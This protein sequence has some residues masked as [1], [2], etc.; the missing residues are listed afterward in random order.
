MSVGATL[1]LLRK[2]TII[3]Y[4]D[5]GTMTIAIDVAGSAYKSVTYV[6]PL[7]LAWSNSKGGIV[8]GFPARGSA[9]IATQGQGGSWYVVSYI[10]TDNTFGTSVMDD[11]AEGRILLQTENRANRIFLDPKSG[12]NLGDSNNNAIY[13]PKRGI[14]SSI[15]K[16]NYEFTDAKRS[17]SGAIKRDLN[18][19]LTRNITNS[20]LYSNEYDD[21]LYTIGMDPSTKTAVK[22]SGG[23]IRNLPLV[24]NKN[25][26]YEFQNLSPSIG[27]TTDEDEYN[28]YKSKEN[29]AKNILPLRTENKTQGFGLGLS[30][31]NHLIETIAGTGVDLFGNILDINR[32]ILP[33]G[34]LEDN[35]FSK[36]P[37]NE[38]AFRNIRDNHRKALAYHF[39]LN[40]RKPG[41]KDSIASVP[42]I[43][44]TKD[45]SRDRSRMFFDIDKEGQF[46]INIP[47]SSEIGNIPLH[48]RYE[49]STSMLY[50]AE[51]ISDPNLFVKPDNNI[52]VYLDNFAVS[53]GISLKSS[54]TSIDSESPLDR[55][56]SLPIKYGTVHHDITNVLNSYVEGSAI[57]D[58]LYYDPDTYISHVPLYDRIVSNKIIINGDG[59]NAGGRSGDI[60][61]DGFLSLN[62]GANTIDRQS[63]WLDMAGGMVSMYGRDKNNIS[64]AGNFDGDILWQI[65]GV[66]AIPGTVDSRFANL[67]NG[68]RSGAFDLRVVNKYGAVSMIR[69]DENGV[70]ISSAAN[71]EIA[72]QNSITFRSNSDIQFHGET[73]R[74]FY[75]DDSLQ[76][77]LERGPA[78]QL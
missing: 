43:T 68:I 14:S 41:P 74:F 22:T 26:I 34:K 31:P 2:G 40:A 64:W 1:G 15:F 47:M 10:P 71:I 32:A 25:I 38:D 77:V 18:I 56:T 66:S 48:T 49:T 75:K 9:I 19:N 58:Q 45:Y 20:M 46:K 36:N 3:G 5:D 65:G 60:N 72:S 69:I 78:M 29:P 39:E 42:D 30:F 8:T 24:E 27:F 61:L 6:V 37:K 67:N 28:R 54:N 52:D 63:L 51:K 50:A 17:I 73:I 16:S 13:D 59:A 76:R 4:N 23:A 11:F 33:I 21:T 55:I 62:V 35:T 70:T 7:P 53:P 12:I 57:I 44:K